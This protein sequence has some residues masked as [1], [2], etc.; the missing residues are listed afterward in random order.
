GTRKMQEWM[1]TTKD[2]HYEGFFMYGAAKGH[3][4]SGPVTS[5]DRLKEMAQ[6]VLRSMP[7]ETVAGWW[8]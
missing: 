1:K 3:C 7:P 2:P 5:A 6:Q 8:K 4:Y